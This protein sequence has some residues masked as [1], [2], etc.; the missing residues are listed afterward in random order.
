MKDEVLKIQEVDERT[1]ST[2]LEGLYQQIA[3]QDLKDYSINPSLNLNNRSAS[4]ISK[5]SE[6][7]K[8]G[9]QD[10][11]DI[12]TLKNNN[13][14]NSKIDKAFQQRVAE[15]IARNED[16]IYD[17][18][19]LITKNID[20]EKKLIKEISIED[21]AIIKKRLN[22]LAKKE[23]IDVYKN[24]LLT[25]SA[26]GSI[27]IGSMII[28]PGAISSILLSET[29]KTA[30]ALAASKTAPIWGYLLVASGVSSILNNDVLPKTSFFEK[31]SSFFTSNEK[32][33]KTIENNL[34]S[35][36][37]IATSITSIVSSIA[38][39]NF[40]SSIFD[41]GT[42][43]EILKVGSTIASGSVNYLSQKHQSNINYLN[44]DKTR[45]KGKEDFHNFLFDKNSDDL[46]NISELNE[47]FN[48]I[49]FNIIQTLTRISDQNIN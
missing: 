32:K 31:I 34:K 8:S 6:N 37:N 7:N 2:K 20:F 49:A 40:I 1:K 4:S 17:I 5:I 24:I 3:F 42:S 15:A 33:A 45:L 19:E 23:N 13:L 27:A 22:E 18:A 43:F 11:F 9:I 25:I 41:W 48:K 28:A 16:I 47:T 10:L 14:N 35:A 36:V 30:A 39:S 29:A 44:S 26:A 12:K 38:T 46:K 21:Q